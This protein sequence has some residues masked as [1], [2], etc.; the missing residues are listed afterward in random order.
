MFNPPL[1][2]PSIQQISQKT[3]SFDHKYVWQWFIVKSNKELFRNIFSCFYFSH[4]WSVKQHN[5]A[6]VI[7]I[8]KKKQFLYYP[9]IFSSII[10]NA[11]ALVIMYT[12]TCMIG[13]VV[14]AY[15]TIQGCDPLRGG[16][17]EDPNQV[18]GLLALKRID[19]KSIN[20]TI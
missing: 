8:F 18:F 16:T 17:I 9:S 5:A 11:P 13:L 2:T 10:A 14:Y 20:I 4:S 19:L 7:L 6:H 1:R 12:L 15:Y 3:Q